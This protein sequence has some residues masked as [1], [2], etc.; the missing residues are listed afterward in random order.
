MKTGT[1]LFFFLFHCC[2]LFGQLEHPKASPLQEVVQQI[3][4]TR[5]R[6]V[7]SRPAV[8]GRAIFGDLVP[9]G[10][11][12]RVGANES[13]KFSVSDSIQ[14]GPYTLPEGTYALY[15]FPYKDY[16]DVVFHK[17]TEHWGDGRDAYRPEEDQF[18]LR[19]K[20]ETTPVVQENF[21]ISFDEIT[22]NSM[23]MIWHWDKLRLQIPISVNTDA[24]ME[25]QLRQALTETASA[26]TWYEAARY[27]QEQNKDPQ[28]AL[29]YV[30]QALA[31]GGDTYYFHRVRSLL[32]AKLGRFREAITAAGISRELAL[33]EG[34]DEFVR[35]N[36]KNI[37]K[38]KPMREN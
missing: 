12:W 23:Q 17:N 13:T 11:I 1:L 7:Y 25:A 22:H 24:V 21:Q 30:E 37:E 20:P 28:R 36:E 32:L 19:L 26:Q 33:A 10:R 4:L 5:V 34:K 14:V 15:A 2:F 29:G 3:G 31:K 27:L 9:Y 35:M 18:R 16:W 38:W 8:R 6:V